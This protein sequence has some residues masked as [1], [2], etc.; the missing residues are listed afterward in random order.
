MALPRS[1][2]SSSSLP[3]DQPTR[4]GLD[5][6]QRSANPVFVAFANSKL[7]ALESPG[8]LGLSRLVRRPRPADDDRAV[9]AQFPCLA[10]ARRRKRM[11]GRPEYPL[12]L[13]VLLVGVNPAADQV[14]PGQGETDQTLRVSSRTTFAARREQR[15]SE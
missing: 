5:D 6:R 10:S 2:G 7:L 13:G 14:I 3:Q 1:L 9:G 8:S 11:V 15:S 4:L 12:G